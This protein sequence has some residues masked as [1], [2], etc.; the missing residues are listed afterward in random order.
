MA[1]LFR[2]MFL[3]TTGLALE[4]CLRGYRTLAANLH[5]LSQAAILQTVSAAGTSNSKLKYSNKYISCYC[6]LLDFW[7]T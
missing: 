6:V 1:A 7:Y 2:I 4:S 5:S 3:F